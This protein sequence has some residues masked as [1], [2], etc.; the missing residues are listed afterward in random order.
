MSLAMHQSTDLT[1]MAFGFNQRTSSAV[2]ASPGNPVSSGRIDSR[3]PPGRVLLDAHTVV[4]T[5]WNGRMTHARTPSTG[6]G[7]CCDAR[8]YTAWAEFNG[9]GDC[10]IR[11]VR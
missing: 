11:G 1:S 6:R 5:S 9:P 10:S 3:A 2:Q 8:F 7:T 4:T